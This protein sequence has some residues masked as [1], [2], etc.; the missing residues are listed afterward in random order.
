MNMIFKRALFE[1]KE[2]K[3]MYP[4]SE[5]GRAAKC[6]NDK[7]IRDVL[8]GASDKLMLVIGPCS[9]DHEECVIDYIS[10]LRPV[11]D[12]VQELMRRLRIS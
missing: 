7:A 4:V 11:Q 6:A 10:R 1:P 12:K 3:E 5:E 8:T 2:I 9:A